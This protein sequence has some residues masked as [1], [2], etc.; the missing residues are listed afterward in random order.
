MP[1]VEISPQAMDIFGPHSGIASN[2][3][4]LYVCN[5]KYTKETVFRGAVHIVTW[6]LTPNLPRICTSVTRVKICKGAVFRAAVHIAT[7]RLTLDLCT[8]A[9]RVKNLVKGTVLRADS[10][11]ASH[12]A[13][14]IVSWTYLFTF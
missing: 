6:R 4:S 7:L 12:H 10:F 13:K 14:G 8:S 9:T 1:H 2:L 3:G 11:I 5:T